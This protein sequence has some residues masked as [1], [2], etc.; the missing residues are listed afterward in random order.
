MS[1]TTVSFLRRCMQVVVV[2]A[3]APGASGAQHWL[4]DDSSRTNQ[5]IFRA[6][7]WSD[8][9]SLRNAA[10]SPGPD[11]WQQQVDYRIEARLD[12]VEHAVYGTERITYHNNSPDRLHYLWLQLD[13]NVRSIEHSRS[14]QIQ[15]ALPTE[16]SPQARQRMSL[17]PFDGGH[18]ITRVQVL[19]GGPLRNTRYIIN[20]TVMRVDLL[21]PLE[22]GSSVEFEIDWNFRVPDQARGSKELVS[23]GWI[24]QLAQ[25]FPRLSVYDDVNGWQTDQ[26]LGSGEFYLEFGNYDVKLTVPWDHMLDATGVL[27]NPEEVLT[28]TQR[29]R[30]AEAMESEDPLFI[31]R[32]DEVLTPGSRPVHS[33][34]LTWHYKA[35]NVRDFAWA[36]SKT[37]VWDAAG[38]RYQPDDR[39]IKLYSLYPRVAM[40][41]WDSVSTRA[42]VQTMK[43]YGRMAFEYP[44]HKAT[45]VNG[46]RGGGM[47]YPMM[48]FCGGR[49]NP[50]GSLTDRI[51]N[52]LVT[53]TI[54]EVGHNWFPM[55]VAS[56][57]RKWGWMDEGLN[58]FLE[59]Y[60]ELDWDAQFPSTDGSAV[61][62]VNH[63]RN[64]DQVPIM[65]A[66]DL[67]HRGGFETNYT[68]PATGLMMLREEILGP[69]LFDAAFREYSQKW[70]FKK[71]QP[72]D[73]YRSMEDGA[74]E[75]LNWFWRGWFYTTHYNDQALASV[76]SQGAEELVGDTERGQQY[77]RMQV[78]NEGGIV[79]PLYLGITYQDGSS[80]TIKLPVDIWRNNE[81]TFTYGFF[82]DKT[83]V[84]VVVDPDEVFADVNRDNNTW[85]A[86]IP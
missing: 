70:M 35:E 53:L 6:L 3:L 39:P 42:I 14:Y 43:T 69:E 19:D 71:P 13:Q 47:E 24:Y 33:G 38:F 84:Q 80:E 31:V 57:E 37:F 5:S 73:F 4:H 79:M 41:L 83:V 86:P 81:L 25:W 85:T 48:A 76:S 20:N 23:D 63:M 50:D 28:A 49:P 62:I 32:P 82:T 22:S 52:G 7:D 27:Q 30:I 29:A 78:D 16:I 40:P 9:T 11:Y 68:K 59:E 77:Y 65:T 75:L 46:G 26:F 8:P 2:A 58:T 44:Y 10:G 21:T 66:P 1:T 60:A 56:D 54:H 17:D 36:S 67:Q 34:T 72:A 61:E 55:I 15:G 12:T 18:N 51:V 74:G 64:P 45:N